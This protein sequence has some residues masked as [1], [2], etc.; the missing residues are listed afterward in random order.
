MSLALCSHGGNS[1]ELGMSLEERRALCFDS[2]Y[3]Y[4]EV[5]KTQTAGQ[6]CRVL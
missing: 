3:P 4:F 2:M 5:M 6:E 1:Y